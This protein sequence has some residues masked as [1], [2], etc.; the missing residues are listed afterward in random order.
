VILVLEFFLAGCIIGFSFLLFVTSLL[1]Y[2]RLRHLR[3]A[4][5]A[6]AF[7]LFLIKGMMALLGA[8]IEGL[9]AALTV[10]YQ[11]LILD[12]LILLLLYLAVA[13]R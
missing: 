8:T 7:L 4:Y 9:Q 6:V 3:F 2:M 5:I 1:S 13:K 10:P 12:L 11:I